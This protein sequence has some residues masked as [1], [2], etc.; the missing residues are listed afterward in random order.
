MFLVYISVHLQIVVGKRI[1]F[2]GVGGESCGVS[3]L[4]RK[5][6][7]LRTWSQNMVPPCA[8]SKKTSQSNE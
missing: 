8:V 3:P 2:A 1:S 4:G 6:F 5:H 7:L